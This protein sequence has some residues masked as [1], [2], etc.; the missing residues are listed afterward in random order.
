[1]CTFSQCITT[2][3]LSHQVGPISQTATTAEATE[4]GFTLNSNLTSRHTP[5]Y[6]YLASQ[7][8]N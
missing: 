5:W 3:Q 4:L 7:D 2:C 6:I 1:M 8:E